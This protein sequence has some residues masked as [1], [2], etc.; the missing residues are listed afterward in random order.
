MEL[1]WFSALKALIAIAVCAA[2]YF[3]FKGG[4]KKTSIGIALV[5]LFVFMYQPVKLT[6][7][8]ESEQKINNYDNQSEKVEIERHETGEYSPKS[9]D[10]DIK[11]ILGE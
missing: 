5:G 1:Y 11:E 8:D 7:V 6:H 2:S 10:E 3:S 9:N 4:L